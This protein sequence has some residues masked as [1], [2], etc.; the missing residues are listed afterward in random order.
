MACR[1]RGTLVIRP[2]SNPFYQ[3]ASR[4]REAL[5]LEYSAPV[6]EKAPREKRPEDGFDFSFLYG[7]A[8]ED[9]GKEV[10]RKSSK[11]GKAMGKRLSLAEMSKLK[12]GV[13]SKIVVEKPQIKI[14]DP[15][16]LAEAICRVY[17][18]KP[19]KEH[20]MYQ[21]SANDYGNQ[22]PTVAT[23]AAERRARSQQFSN[24]FNGIKYRD[25]GLNTST[26]KSHVHDNIDLF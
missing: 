21:T 22:G 25:Q 16:E 2:S 13:D 14:T 24:S 5:S 20:I 11:L 9:I 8:Q 7:R 6:L 18:H 23:V 15:T 10:P 4:E 1:G 3:P 12:S 17:S 26:T 19:K